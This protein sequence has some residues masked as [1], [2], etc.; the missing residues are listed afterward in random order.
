M[1]SF[2]LLGSASLFIDGRPL[3]QFRSQKEAAL[4][5]YLAHTGQSQSREL[6][7]DLLWEDRS[8]K[9]ALSNLR[10]VL[11]RLRKQ[12]GG[13]L[14]ITRKAVALTPESRQQVDSASLL[15]TLAN[16]QQIGSSNTVAT[17]QQTLDSYH[18][19]FLADFHLDDAPQFNQWVVTTR[20]QIHRQVIATYDRLT[21]F[22]LTSGDVAQGIALIQRWLSVDALDEAAHTLLIRLLLQDGQT[23]A[24][25]DHYEHCTKLLRKELG[26]APPATMTELIDS[27]VRPS[28]PVVQPPEL[29][30]SLRAAPL[31]IQP[32]VDHPRHNLPAPHDQFFGR[33]AAQQD[34]AERL[35]QPWCRLVTIIGQGGVGKT[36]L[37]TTV[38][39][40]RCNDF[41]DGVWLV[42]LADIDPEDEELTEA[43]AVEIATVLDL[44]LSG[45]DRP[46]K[47]LLTH[48]QHKQ[49]L[50]LFDNF[51]HLLEG[52]APL[53]TDLLDDCDGIQILVTSREPLR[54]RAEWT[55][56][57]TGLGYPPIEQERHSTTKS[58]ETCLETHSDAVD[59]FVARR[60][61]H[62]RE[63]LPSADY[64][65]VRQI[66]QL[67]EGLPLALELAAA[68][69]RS[70][71]LQTIADELHDG[72]DALTT[73]VRDVPERHR[74]LQIVFEMSW[75][76]LA[77]ALQQRLARLSIF[78]GGFTT[79]AARQIADTD[80]IH[81]SA[82]SEKS[83]LVH[84]ATTGRYALHPVIR[85]YAATKL[86][87]PDQL[88]QDHA[89][90]YLTLLARQREMLQKETPQHAVSILA[91]ELENVRL[92]WQTELARRHTDLLSAALTPLSIVYQLR[93]LAHEAEATMQ[94]TLR[95][96]TTWG[97]DG[98]VLA[99]RAGLER[100]RF[101]NRLG[102]YRAA[103]ETVAAALRHAHQCGD[104]W[105]EGMGHVLW[106]E[107][108]WRLGEY[109]EAQQKLNHA[110]AVAQAIDAGRESILLVGWCHHHLGVIDDIQ[111][112][113][114]DAIFHLEQACT[115]WQAIGRTQALSS[116]LNSIGL[117]YYNNGDI[118][119][120]QQAME[121]S[122][123]ICNH[124]DNRYLQSL[125]LNNLSM[126]ATEQ[127]DFISAHHYLQ[128]GL[129]VATANGDMSAQSY[130]R[131]NLG[132]NYRLLGKTDL[133]VESLEMGVQLS[134][135][136]GN[137]ALLATGLFYLAETK[138]DQRNPEQAE[139][140]YA[141]ALTI[142]RQDNLQ[143]LAC[144]I[145]VGRAEFLSKRNESEAR[146]Y[147]EQAI[148]LAETI[149]N[150]DMLQRATAVN[151]YLSI[152]QI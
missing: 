27:V 36:R 127:R 33:V 116:S 28:A 58:T 105:A 142:A 84:E 51:E 79:E 151:A 69:T 66:C 64:A 61:Q 34:I 119:A 32:P 16:H 91:P 128:I 60:A 49:M 100:A 97:A 59:L 5:I 136:I 130:V 141:Q 42:E 92:A 96:A 18:G 152:S 39:R 144:E 108:L 13:A 123:T 131:T 68:L 132:K 98:L 120:A 78:R 52:G 106:G 14:K 45:S 48:L 138:R 83:L 1:L 81:L 77:P 47:Q 149:Q 110:L 70:R 139:A 124:L 118:E 71:P 147:S 8:T 65:L 112:R 41:R 63:P 53:V 57:L 137:R 94:N 89:H 143:H 37:A 20:E 103:M 24:A 122:L 30:K 129:E 111:S 55:V 115:A 38:A 109:E 102:R 46:V 134:E 85:A 9:Q 44:R 4:L 135:S 11:A 6:I 19:E 101:Q 54:M 82:L 125:L 117:I 140:L 121:Q 50:L 10:T 93:G 35:D 25:L 95:K 146:K 150:Q 99:T 88:L 113:Y 75:Q 7:A 74:S 31:V 43:I 67:V 56:A 21:Q 40:D 90:Y 23:R 148:K 145:L 3:N 114:D 80:T 2:Q 87:N 126:I 86:A 29:A 17:L 72:F 107:S 73:S 15:Q 62:R 76:T 22:V 104:R 133:A 26:I 12:I